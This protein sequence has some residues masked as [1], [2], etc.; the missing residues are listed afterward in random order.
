MVAPPPTARVR[1][2]RS[3]DGFTIVEAVVAMVLLIVFATTVLA[4]VATTTRLAGQFRSRTV[5]TELAT[6]EIATTR[7]AVDAGDLSTDTLIDGD[8]Q[9]TSTER[10]GTTYSVTRTIGLSTATEGQSL[11]TGTGT[12]LSGADRLMVR[13]EV[14]VTWSDR[15]TM[16]PVRLVE[17]VGLPDG[18][19]TG[20]NALV[21]AHVV[22]PTNGGAGVPGVAIE[23]QSNLWYYSVK[24]GRTTDSDG[25]VVV[26]VSGDWAKKSTSYT[27]VATKSGY[28]G[29]A[30]TDTAATLI[31]K[32]GLGANSLVNRVEI[33]Y[34]PSA[35]LRVHLTNEDG[36]AAATDE[37]AA[38][39][40]LTL[41]CASSGTAASDPGKVTTL[42]A[43]VTEF[44]AVWPCLYSAYVGEELPATMTQVDVAGG[45]T[46]DLWVR[47]GY[48]IVPE[49]RGT[50]PEPTPTE[51][52]TVEPSVEP[53]PE[54]SV[55]PEPDPE[56]TDDPL[57]VPDPTESGD[58]A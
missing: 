21:V 13:I 46:V 26:Q 40:N 48:G 10:A 33:S 50:T 51:E 1:T 54:P 30:W 49:P 29:Q 6:S 37:Q 18:L 2:T 57:P 45:A 16:A 34:A 5:A 19:T 11:C 35:T 42:T 7:V 27:A 8:T 4:A 17:F 23:L 44:S 41:I 56:T 20:K 43:A 36:T 55:G 9:D 14:S 25:C 52:P 22:D 28:V 31:G 15:T 38:G 32:L 24:S 47:P 12:S 53:S 58:A 3:D 39:Q